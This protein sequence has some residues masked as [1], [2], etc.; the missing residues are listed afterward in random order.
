VE[1]TLDEVSIP[2][3]SYK[4]LV[5]DAK[6]LQFLIDERCV[7][8]STQIWE[9]CH[10]HLEWPFDGYVQRSWYTSA[11]EAIDAQREEMNV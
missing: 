10:Y 5:Q 3:S 6:R 8:T 4:S 2:A 7:I 11:E 1:H 9:K